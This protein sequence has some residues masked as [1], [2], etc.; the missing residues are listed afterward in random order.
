MFGCEFRAVSYTAFLAPG[1]VTRLHCALKVAMEPAVLPNVLARDAHVQRKLDGVDELDL[2]AL[3]LT[4]AVG[5][6]ISAKVR[7][8]AVIRGDDAALSVEHRAWPEHRML[9]TSTAAQESPYLRGRV[10]W[11][12]LSACHGT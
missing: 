10:A 3:G 11:G 2:E 4:Q 8:A 6:L 7:S 5:G 9:A 1:S 12:I